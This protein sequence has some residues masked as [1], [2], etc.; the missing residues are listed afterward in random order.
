MRRYYLLLLLLL[1]AGIAHAQSGPN[2]PCNSSATQK[3]TAFANITT[4]TTTALVPV[5]NNTAIFIC[6]VL[7]TMTATVA[8]DTLLF[9]QGT[10][11]S[12]AGT[13]TALT[14]T[15]SSGI[16]TAGATVLPWG[17]GSGTLFKTAASNGLCAVTTVGTGPSIAVTITFV[18]QNLT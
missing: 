18:Q 4:A 14:A 15:Y 10:G 11:S 6:S 13:P 5:S 1:F 8:A 9:E 12:C 16:L 3:Q 7:V 2:D 17:S